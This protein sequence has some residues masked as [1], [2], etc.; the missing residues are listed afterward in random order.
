MPRTHEYSTHLPALTLAVQLTEGSVLD[1][2]GGIFST[3]ILH[4]MLYS[5]NRFLL[6]VDD[7]ANWMG[8][9]HGMENKFHQF[10]HVTNLKGLFKTIGKEWDVALIDYGTYKGRLFCL[11]ELLPYAKIIILHDY[12][13]ENSDSQWEAH[14][15]S[16]KDVQDAVNEVEYKTLFN[17]QAP[18]T[19]VL[20]NFVNI[21]QK[22]KDSISWQSQLVQV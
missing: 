10:R 8:N 17:A 22:I 19:A 5:T 12:G 6:T 9:F 16:L 18:Y 14:G 20:S 4:D 7:S 11:K 1:L 15:V 21:E 3:F 2:G 13:D